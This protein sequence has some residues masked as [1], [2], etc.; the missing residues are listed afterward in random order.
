MRRVAAAI[1]ITIAAFVM[2]AVGWAAFTTSAGAAPARADAPTCASAGTSVYT[3]VPPKDA[4][5]VWHSPTPAADAPVADGPSD[6]TP[7]AVAADAPAD[8]LA[9]T[10]AD[11]AGMVVVALL[12][13][14]AGTLIVVLGRRRSAAR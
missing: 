2:S 14:G 3:C 6:A 9:F 4:P 10:G 11:I 5:P 7:S 13:I 8:G 1:G 12:L